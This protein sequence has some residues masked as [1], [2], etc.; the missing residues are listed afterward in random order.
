MF[1]AALVLET[2]SLFL[3]AFLIGAVSGL[4]L[5]RLTAPG[6]AAI[7]A[8]RIVAVTRPNSPALV[9]APQI[10][11]ISARP[12]APVTRT[13]D[14]QP[15][16]EPATADGAPLATDEAPSVPIADA[17]EPLHAVGEMTEPQDEVGSKRQPA[18]TAGMATEESDPAPADASRVP[19]I[20]VDPPTGPVRAEEVP[21]IDELAHVVEPSDAASAPT[22][23]G[24][25]EA[26][27]PVVAVKTSATDGAGPDPD[28]AAGPEIAPIEPEPAPASADLDREQIASPPQAEGEPATGDE[29]AEA[30]AMRAIEGGWTPRRAPAQPAPT[31]ELSPAE[32]AAAIE[33]ARTAVASAASA[34]RTALSD[35]VVSDGTVGDERGLDFEPAGSEPPGDVLMPESEPHVSSAHDGLSF[36]PRPVHTGFGRP[37]VLSAARNGEPDNLKQ[38]KGIT[39]QLETSLHGLGI[40][41][42]DQVADWDQKAVVWL[43]QHLSL[44]GRIVREHWVEQARTLLTGRHA[45]AP[46]PVRR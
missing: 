41:H 42:F 45:A 2:A 3:V 13:E 30:A 15:S 33:S 44:H 32:V 8:D 20:T 23:A 40:F 37:P 17:A 34:A 31:P 1:N 38:I 36:E 26:E 12:P 24:G 27:T 10:A 19:E 35:A 9:V 6:A 29:D 18:R 16:G 46:R 14:H 5:R 7:P 43:D 11:P 25:S 39:P 21:P 4:L 28:A 22:S